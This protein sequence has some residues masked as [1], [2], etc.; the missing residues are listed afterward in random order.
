MNGAFSALAS[1]AGLAGLGLLRRGGSTNAPAVDWVYHATTPSALPAIRRDGLQPRKPPVRGQPRA[2]YFAPTPGHALA[3]GSSQALLRFP[4]PD[5]WEDDAYGDTTFVED[6]RGVEHLVRTSMRSPDPVLPELI[7]LRVGK[8]WVPLVASPPEPRG[9]LQTGSRSDARVRQ[10]LDMGGCAEGRLYHVTRAR[11]LPTI[12][13]HGLVANPKRIAPTFSYFA[14][15]SH[16]RERV[17]LAAG[18]PA[19]AEWWMSIRMQREDEGRAGPNNRLALLRVRPD[20]TAAYASQLEHDMEGA[21]DVH[22]CS[23]ALKGRVTP[24][25]LEIARPSASFGRTMPEVIERVW[26][27]QGENIERPFTWRPLVIDSAIGS[28]SRRVDPSFRVLLEEPVVDPETGRTL[29]IRVQTIENR[30]HDPSS[31]TLGA[32]LIADRSVDTSEFDDGAHDVLGSVLADDGQNWAIPACTR[33]LRDFDP[34]RPRRLFIVGNSELGEYSGRG[35][36]LAVYDALAR[37]AA[38]LGAAISPHHCAPHGHTNQA[39]HRVWEKLAQRYLSIGEPGLTI[40][41]Q[42]YD[43]EEALDAAGTPVVVWAKW[44]IG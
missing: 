19:A 25:D 18:I 2:V 30:D 39:A 31:A 6:E 15:S 5:D 8:Q 12:R 28:R 40:A 33:A 43:D 37:G 21:R 16:L 36:G 1:V 29:W 38:L 24:E 3:W 9:S 14:G 41:E 27:A 20:R 32:F 17:F 42:D 44:R 35:L 26:D 34:P 4:W 22:T 7:E 23:F 11:L 13:T 10:L